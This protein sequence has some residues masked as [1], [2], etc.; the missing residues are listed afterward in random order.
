M[1]A[2]V[3]ARAVNAEILRIGLT[4]ILAAGRIGNGHEGVL[5]RSRALDDLEHVRQVD[6]LGRARKQALTGIEGPFHGQI[7]PS[8]GVPSK[9]ASAAL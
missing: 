5:C 1:I 9:E 4:P 8:L 6:A 3:T 2:R 7:K